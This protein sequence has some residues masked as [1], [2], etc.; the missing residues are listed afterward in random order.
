MLRSVCFVYE[1]IKVHMMCISFWGEDERVW[2]GSVDIYFV[3]LGYVR[4][5][6]SLYHI[7]YYYIYCTFQVYTTRD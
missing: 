7:L 1:K 5:I 6:V 3:Y 2:S 4:Y